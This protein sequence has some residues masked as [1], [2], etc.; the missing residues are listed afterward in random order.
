MI[1][2]LTA[3]Y[4]VISYHDHI[5][6]TVTR[7][8]TDVDRWINDIMIK[9]R[10][11]LDKLVIGI[12]TE[13]CLNATKSIAILQLCVGH[14]CLIFQLLH[15]D[16]IP[17][18]LYAF[19]NNT[20]FTFVGVGIKQDVQKL[21]EYRELH[22]GGRIMD[23]R[24]EAALIY[25]DN[26]IK[27]IGLKGLAKKV[28]NMEMEKPRDITLS[29]WDDVSLSLAQHQQIEAPAEPLPSYLRCIDECLYSS[30]VWSN[31]CDIAYH[32]AWVQTKYGKL[33]KKV[34]H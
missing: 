13:W 15:A 7:R 26:E 5:L 19:L 8:G 10:K 22:V 3:V 9:H 29:R 32:A 28:L 4:V 11:Q 14:H 1:E 34:D 21:S 30:L 18:S 33:R 25:G 6:T 20:N 12:D 16:E 31:I 2:Q 24:P 23:L 27:C 17:A